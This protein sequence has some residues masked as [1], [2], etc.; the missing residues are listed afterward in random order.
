[1]K[2]YRLGLV[3]SSPEH[4]VNYTSAHVLIRIYIVLNLFSST[5]FRTSQYV[6]ERRMTSHIAEKMVFNLRVS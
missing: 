4:Y 6:T 2:Q 3:L 5:L 1:M